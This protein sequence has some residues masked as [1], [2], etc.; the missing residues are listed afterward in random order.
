MPKKR[1]TFEII[2]GVRRAKA[3]Q[4]SGAT[5]IRAFIQNADGT[6]GPETE[7]PIASLR[8]RYKDEIDMS[9]NQQAD[10]F[11]SVWKAIKSGKADQVPPIIVQRGSRG[12]R[13]EDVG[14]KY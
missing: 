4:L 3:F 2:Q 14:W 9:T 8:S 10:R 11:W 7:L 13:I 5:F 1:G 6:L 12:K